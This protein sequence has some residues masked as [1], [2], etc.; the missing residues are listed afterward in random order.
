MGKYW[1]LVLAAALALALVAGSLVIA[2]LH[3]QTEEDPLERLAAA[4]ARQPDAAKAAE[5]VDTAL[6]AGEIDILYSALNDILSPHL[7]TRGVTEEYMRGFKAYIE[8]ALDLRALELADPLAHLNQPPDILSPLTESYLR[9]APQDWVLA[10]EVGAQMMARNWLSGEG[11]NMYCQAHFGYILQ[12]PFPGANGGNLDINLLARGHAQ[13]E[14]TQSF[15][16]DWNLLGLWLS[17]AGGG[18]PDYEQ[19]E[20]QLDLLGQ[21]EYSSEQALDVYWQAKAMALLIPLEPGWQHPLDWDVIEELVSVFPRLSP[22]WQEQVSRML[23]ALH[24]TAEQA[25]YLYGISEYTLEEACQLQDTMLTALG[26]A[27]ISELGALPTE[28]DQNTRQLDIPAALWQP[29]GRQIASVLASMA[30]SWPGNE[31]LKLT[32]SLASLVEGQQSSSLVRSRQVLYYFDMAYYQQRPGGQNVQPALL[33][34]GIPAVAI[35]DSRGGITL[36]DLER[37]KETRV[38]GEMAAWSPAGDQLA[39]V[40]NKEGKFRIRVLARDGTVTADFTIGREYQQFDWLLWYTPDLLAIEI[41]S[42]PGVVEQTVVSISGRSLT[43]RK[44]GRPMQRIP[45]SDFLADG[46]NLF[47]LSGAMLGTALDIDPEDR[48]N[49]I[50][51]PQLEA[52]IYCSDDRLIYRDKA[53][54]EKNIFTGDKLEQWLADKSSWAVLYQKKIYIGGLDAVAEFDTASGNVRFLHP[55]WQPESEAKVASPHPFHFWVAEDTTLP[56][57]ALEPEG[58]S[59]AGGVFCFSQR[60][61]LAVYPVHPAGNEDNLPLIITEFR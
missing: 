41:K 36:F 44:P 58:A 39:V 17:I 45:G 32:G 61:V 30:E 33:S 51:I 49:T 28:D 34:P 26:F 21:E 52:R 56:L 46:N 59:L 35:P 12:S 8:T 31:E 6:A 54:W 23:L 38:S 15:R 24:T 10:L 16:A 5:I 9:H 37:W 57:V 22:Q 42:R 4:M 18:A 2:H 29:Q 20:A 40:S 53:G 25:L 7:D 48:D 13:L 14:K 19:V 50:A 60:Y 47:S 1:R 11:L 55:S 43:E 27:D 3:Q